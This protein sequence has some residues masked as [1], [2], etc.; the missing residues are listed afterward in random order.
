MPVFSLSSD[1]SWTAP[2]Y[3]GIRPDPDKV[4]AVQCMQAP[5]DVSGVCRSLGVVNQLSKFIPNAVELI[6]PLR[7]LL[8]KDHQWVW[9]QP[10]VAAVQEIKRVLIA[11]P[12]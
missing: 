9:R 5:T 3:S 8:L 1:T 6:R 11:I 12:S 4:K 10:Q 2:G 7:Y